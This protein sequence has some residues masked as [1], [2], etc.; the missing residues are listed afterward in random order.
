MYI[1]THTHTHTRYTVGTASEAAC[2][3]KQ[4]KGS[5]NVSSSGGQSWF[6]V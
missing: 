6:R 3:G 5:G 4:R 1:H 2:S